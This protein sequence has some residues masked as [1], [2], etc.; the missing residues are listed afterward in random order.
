MRKRDGKILVAECI[1]GKKGRPHEHRT[2]NAGHGLHDQRAVGIADGAVQEQVKC[3]QKGAGNR[4]KRCPAEDFETRLND[5]QGAAEPDCDR[6]PALPAHLVAE[7]DGR[8]HRQHEWFDEIDR[9]DIRKR[10]VFDGGEEHQ[11]GRGVQHAAQA[12][13]PWPFGA[14]QRPG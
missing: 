1:T 14:E 6:R 8:H 4:Q 2:G 5:D 10:H 13:H 7:E 11:A 9:E 3:V 12:V